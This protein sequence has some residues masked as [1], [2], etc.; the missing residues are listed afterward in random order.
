LSQACLDVDCPVDQTCVAGVCKDAF[1][2]DAKK[3][4][5][6]GCGEDAL[7]GGG[8]G[9]AGQGGGGAGQ[10]GAG[11]GGSGQGGAPP[12]WQLELLD[13]VPGAP[14]LDVHGVSDDGNVV[15][16]AA[17]FVGGERLAYAWRGSAA[18]LLEQ[19]EE[20]SALA[21]SHDGAVI[22]GSLTLALEGSVSWE[23]AGGAYG[24]TLRSW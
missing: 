10:G 6:E 19:S 8:T 14:S 2:D 23:W 15:V 17:H 12:A 7:G 3:C 24:P 11:Q 16:G 21:V 22:V 9:G 5:G 1:I 18:L 4:Q 20:G 13:E